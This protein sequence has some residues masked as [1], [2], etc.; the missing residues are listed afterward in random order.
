M[1]H[2]GV[3]Q[4]HPHAS[5]RKDAGSPRSFACRTMYN[6]AHRSG[7]CPDRPILPRD[8]TAYVPFFPLGGFNPLQSSMLVR[9][10]VNASAPRRLQVALAWLLHAGAEHP[11]DPRHLLALRIC[12]RTSP[13]R[14]L[15]CRMIR[16]MHWT[17]LQRASVPPE[18]PA[19]HWLRGA[20]GGRTIGV[21]SWQRDRARQSPLFTHELGSA[22]RCCS[23]WFR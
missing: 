4:R 14:N 6:L 2:I 8:G 9:R 3:E 10:R 22:A 21:E 19:I 1:R 5:R 12:A 11:T 23:N 7:R 15:I 17:A 13:R 18:E 20:A 16:L